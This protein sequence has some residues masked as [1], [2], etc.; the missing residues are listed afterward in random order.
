MT[1]ADY[2]ALPD[3]LRAE[4]VDGEVIVNPPP[5]FAHQKICLRLAVLLE[6]ALS[7]RAEVVAGAGWRLPG[8][9]ERIRIPDV[10]VLGHQPDG[11][12][13][14]DAPLAVIEVLSTNRSDDLVRKS[15][16]YLEAKAGQYW[17]VDPRDRVLDVYENEP[18][19]WH[20]LAR[21][22]DDDKEAVVRLADTDIRVP[23]TGV[24]DGVQT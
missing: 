19:G 21:L 15:T 8:T 2:L 20:L 12:L 10:L 5:T 6:R 23:L 4:F 1:L 16:E 18:T 7:D 24:L 9:T 3:D 11:A 22:T 14:R 17:I 13:V